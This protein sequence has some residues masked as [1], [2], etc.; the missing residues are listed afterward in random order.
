[1]ELTRT[2]SFNKYGCHFTG[3][4]VV[5]DYTK[6]VLE[7]SR[8]GRGLPELSEAKELVRDSGL[9][10]IRVLLDIPEYVVEVAI[11]LAKEEQ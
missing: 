8:F 7:N 6:D 2:N 11:T 10:V 3:N 4:L 5:V 9:T 1:M